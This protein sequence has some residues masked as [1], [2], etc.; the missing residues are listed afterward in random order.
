[1][2]FTTFFPFSF[3]I[4][5]SYTP[6]RLQFNGQIFVARRVRCPLLFIRVV[7]KEF[8]DRRNLTTR[9]EL[10]IN[11]RIVVSESASP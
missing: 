8:Y 3:F 9:V 1:M 10:Q 7:G 5:L 11:N 2:R 4:V 6:D